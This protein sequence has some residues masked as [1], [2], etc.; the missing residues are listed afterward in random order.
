MGAPLPSQTLLSL[1]GVAHEILVNC[2]VL[3][4]W[5]YSL[6]FSQ[7]LLSLD[8]IEDFLEYWD[9][10]SRSEDAKDHEDEEVS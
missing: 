7:S 8:L 1:F 3:S 2:I 4:D 9:G 10:Q 5:S 6:V